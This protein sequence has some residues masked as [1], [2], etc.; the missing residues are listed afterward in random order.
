MPQRSS[1]TEGTPNWVDLQTTDAGA[2]KAF[3]S[4]LFGW[5]YEDM[6]MESGGVYSIATLDGDAVAGIAAQS[7][8][9]RAAGAPPSWNTYLAVDD[10]DAATA[11]VAGAGG[12]V[13][14]APF[15]VGDGA[16]RMSVVLD[17]TG[18]PVALWQAGTHIGARRVNEP[19]T[20]IWNELASGDVDRALAFYA[21][22]VG[23]DARPMPMGEEE[24]MML[25]VGEARAGGATGPHMDGVPNHW[26]VWFAVDDTDAT[27]A[28]A[29]SSGGSVLM[30]PSDM[31]VGRAA[32][33]ADPQGAVF[34]IITGP[35]PPE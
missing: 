16:G 11:K 32:T 7:P 27:A 2:A 34:S 17:P 5:A 14:M 22:V 12:Q 24:Y 8:D 19:N 35:A 28:A 25:F 18:V 10:V 3:Y 13:A 31:A 1:Y 6:E 21:E 29:A 9:M 23:L 20:V 33:L 26:H 15:D 30:A 4:T